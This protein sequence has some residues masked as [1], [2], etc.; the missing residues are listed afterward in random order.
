MIKDKNFKI[1]TKQTFKKER[2]R[3]ATIFVLSE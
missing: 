3:E 2:K 1:T